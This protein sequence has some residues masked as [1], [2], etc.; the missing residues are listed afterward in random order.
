MYGFSR[1]T[2]LLPKSLSYKDTFTLR[3]Q[4][5]C[6]HHAICT[7]WVLPITCSL[8]QVRCIQNLFYHGRKKENSPYNTSVLYRY[9]PR[10]KQG[11]V[12][13]FLIQSFEWTRLPN[14]NRSYYSA[15]LAISQ[16]K[17]A[18]RDKPLS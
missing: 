6:S 16:P 4:R 15:L 10:L 17:Q 7:G 1:F 13:T 3:I 12:R 18:S 5:L 11:C 14:T 9:A 8:P 2:F